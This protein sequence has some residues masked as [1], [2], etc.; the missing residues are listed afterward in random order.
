MCKTPT[1]QRQLQIG[2]VEI[3][4]GGGGQGADVQL[5]RELTQNRCVDLLV[6]LDHSHHVVDEFVPEFHAVQTGAA[7]FAAR[8][9][10]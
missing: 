6:L 9:E 2:F 7:R 1:F 3:P 5:L 8:F 10:H 4:Q